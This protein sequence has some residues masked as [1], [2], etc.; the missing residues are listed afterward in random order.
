[1]MMND[2]ISQVV[3]SISG[4]DDLMAYEALARKLDALPNRFPSTKSGVHLRLLAKIFTPQEAR[5]AAILTSGPESVNEIATRTGGDADQLYQQLKGLARRGLIFVETGTGLPRFKLMPFVIGIYE[6]Q[7]ATIDRELAQLFEQYYQEAFMEAMR[8]QPQFH[9]VIPVGESIRNTMEI[10]PYESVIDLVNNA[11][12]WGVL[13]CICRK[14]KALIGD[15]CKHPIDVCMTLSDKPGSYD[16]NPVV[17]ALTKEQALTTLKR[18]TDAGLVHTVSNNQQGVTYICN[19]CT[20]SC[21]ILRGMAKLGVANV[22]AR[23]AFVNTVDQELCTA[24]GICLDYC[25][26]GAISVNGSA[27]VNAMKCVGC[28]V[29]VPSCPNEALKLA[30]RPE[31]EIKPIPETYAEWGKERAASKTEKA[32]T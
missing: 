12:A 7:V 26:F 9:R 25:Q 28:G 18:A 20:C 15:P 32:N 14:Q 8:V 22:V 10:H 31:D 30:R 16:N 19:C 3:K 6:N 23:S 29:C 13:D 4:A 27:Q 5:T 24:C 11:K 21:G 1:M 17:R 2:L